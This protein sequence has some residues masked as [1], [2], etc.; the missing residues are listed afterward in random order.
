MVKKYLEG[1]RT[2]VVGGGERWTFVLYLQKHVGGV[3]DGYNVKCVM[4]YWYWYRMCLGVGP[5]LG[6]GGSNMLEASRKEQQRMF[7][8]S[9]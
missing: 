2:I 5:R 3:W 1:G 9:E 8:F 7:R 6:L 4:G